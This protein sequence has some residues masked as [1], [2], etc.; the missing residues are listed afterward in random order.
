MCIS[1]LALCVFGRGERDEEKEEERGGCLAM[2][3][4]AGREIFRTSYGS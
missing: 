2:P 4:G 1:S 3:F